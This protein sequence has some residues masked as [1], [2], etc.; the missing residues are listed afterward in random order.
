MT[1]PA[2]PR[3]VPSRR[4]R[5]LWLIKGLSAGGAERLLA[6][7][8]ERRDRD[9]FAYE[10]AYLLPW[11]DGLVP[12][13]RAA[14]VPVGCLR[15]GN[16]FD[17]RWALRLRRRLRRRPVDIL[18]LHSP[19]VAGVARLVV[20]TLPKRFRPRVIS[21]EHLPW[22][23]Y[24]AP[25][26]L[27]NRF[28]FPLDDAHIAVSR[29]VKDSIPPRMRAGTRV[30][31]HGIDLRAV[32]SSAAHRQRARRELGVDDGTF[33]VGTVAHLRAQKG[34]TDLLHATRRVLDQ[35]LPVRFVAVGRGPQE[36]ALRALAGQLGLDGAFRFLG[37]RE[38]A[39]H[40]LS[41]FDVFVLASHEEGLPLALMEALTL[42]I[43]IVATDVGGIPEEV[44][45]G[46]E[47]LLVPRGRPDRLAEAII[48]LLGDPERRASMSEA[49][50]ARSGSFDISGATREAERIYEELVLRRHA[51][52]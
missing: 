6:L 8:A 4:I 15:G 19:Y 36:E 20:R 43:P 18:H 29:A 49:A 24:S 31:R 33:L 16:E 17:L 48:T 28:T 35:D 13:L 37:F 1:A 42:G 10:A 34:Y 9:R 5:V 50:R 40:V 22:P 45:D 11:K 23:G 25:T 46:R 52:S 14:G 26:R 12:R 41:A 51:L 2:S 21:T 39:G 3:G 44:T 32:A 27:L 47:G 30:V 38:D 7:M